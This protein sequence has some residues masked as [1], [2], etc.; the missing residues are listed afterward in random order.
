VKEACQELNHN[1]RSTALT[2]IGMAWGIATVVLLLGY[3]S[4]LGTAIENIFTNFGSRVIAVSPGHTSLQAGGAKAG[5]EI[6][7]EVDDVDL[8][9][10]SVPLVKHISPEVTKQCTVQANGRSYQFLIHA[11]QPSIMDIHA[12]QV[13]QGRFLVDEDVAQRAHVLV[14]SS[15]AKT[16]LFSSATALGAT[17][18]LDGFP[19]T[20]VGV[21][22]PKMQF[23]DGDNV[24]RILYVPFSAIDGI[25]S[26]AHLDSIW[27]NYDAGDYQQI[28]RMLRGTLAAAHS[29]N[30]EDPHAVWIFNSMKQFSQFKTI[31]F[32]LKLFLVFIGTITLG[33]GGVGL[34]NIMLASV[35]NRTREIGLRKAVGA[36]KRDI[37]LQF[38]TEAMAITAMGGMIGIGLAVV[39]SFSVGSITLYSAIATHAEAGDIRLAIPAGNLMLA[40]VI[41]FLVGM[42]TGVVPALRAAQLAPME[43]LRH[44]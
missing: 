22:R 13:D 18:R 16:K 34:M 6:Q 17:V 44:E 20:V 15:E 3:G 31:S 26:A 35:T 8:I 21:L 41:L 43:A 25:K 12:L 39:V 30:S 36:C 9:R 27:L 38:L 7:L 40:T 5:M 33:I 37:L 42:I 23:A 4:G 2:V 11:N 24:N 28:E 10:N 29:F 1:R 14:L 19:F 32:A